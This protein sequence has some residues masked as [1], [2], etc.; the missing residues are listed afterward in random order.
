L[1][2]V[3]ITVI[4]NVVTVDICAQVTEDI[5]S[6]AQTRKPLQF[7]GRVPENET[8]FSYDSIKAILKSVN[9][10]GRRRRIDTSPFALVFISSISCFM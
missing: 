3:G 6:P 10:F 2:A 9:V 7:W 1:S 8:L 4:S 5:G